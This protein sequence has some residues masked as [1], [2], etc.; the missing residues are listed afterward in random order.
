M[1]LYRGFSLWEDIALTVAG[2]SAVVIAVNPMEWTAKTYPAFSP[3]VLFS[4][5]TMSAVTFFLCMVFVCTLCSEKTLRFAQ[6]PQYGGHNPNAYRFWYALFALLML[7][8]PISSLWF[9]WVTKQNRWG[10]WLE[11]FGILAFGAFWLVKT[12]ELSR[13]KLDSKAMEGVAPL[14]RKTLMGERYRPDKNPK[15]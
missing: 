15:L 11:A 1:G 3:H 9:D 13:T 4:V 6:F 10:Y 8:S 14:D 5:H 2:I 7:I 12:L